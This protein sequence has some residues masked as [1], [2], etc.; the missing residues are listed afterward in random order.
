[1]TR[2][3]AWTIAIVIV[4]ILHGPLSQA[5]DTS[6]T[7]TEAR[8]EVAHKVATLPDTGQLS[9][10]FSADTSKIVT[11]D[12][13]QDT[14]R[15]WTWKQGAPANHLLAM[16]AHS[17]LS[18]ANIAVAFSP[19]GRY[20]AATHLATLP[21]KTKPFSESNS[22]CRAIQI[23]DARTEKPLVDLDDLQT[24]CIASG[25]AFSNAGDLLFAIENGPQLCSGYAEHVVVFST[26]N[27]KRLWNICV[28]G[29]GIGQLAVSRDDKFVAIGG[30]HDIKVDQTAR[31]DAA[32][33][34]SREVVAIV[35]IHTRQTVRLID[36]ALPDQFAIEALAWSP[37]GRRLAVGGGNRRGDSRSDALK[38]YDP[39]TGQLM[40]NENSSYSDIKGLAYTSDGKYF[41]EAVINKEVRIWDGSHEHLL[42]VFP[43]GWGSVFENLFN[44]LAV[45]S[46]NH[47]LA[48]TLQ[49][50]TTVYE[51]K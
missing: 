45:S 24:G 23:W 11:A 4:T 49:Y 27:W 15:V 37:D 6:S 5:D 16:P 42:Q 44:A 8:A 51:L 3:R 20:L 31:P 26:S 18:S 39:K 19:N 40:F 36:Q 21:D 50:G 1:V 12:I 48:V 22:S 9:V 10:T 34:E 32:E 14:L 46:D 29:N 30:S 43:T 17:E 2:R 41:I 25:V 38:V 28:D 7:I 13:G 33:F 35:D 47:Y